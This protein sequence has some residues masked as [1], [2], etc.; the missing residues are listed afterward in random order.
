MQNSI[1]TFEPQGDDTFNVVYTKELTAISPKCQTALLEKIVAR[2][3]YNLEA[4]TE[5]AKRYAEAG[6]YDQACEVRFRAASEAIDALPEDEEYFELN[7]EDEEVQE[8]IEIIVASGTDFYMHGDF[9]MAAALYETALSLDSE[10]HLDVA[11]SLALS[12]IAIEDWEGYEQLKDNFVPGSMIEALVEN[13]AAFR[14]NRKANKKL[15]QELLDE[16]A[17]DEHIIDELFLAEVDKERVSKEVAARELWY[18]HMPVFEVY[19]QFRAQLKS[20]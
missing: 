19:P 11:S 8:F 16:I 5:L 4:A 7:W 9:E 17:A 12:Y 20:R 14:Q 6:D 10:D 15:P 1:I 3:P 13:F 18:R 2:E